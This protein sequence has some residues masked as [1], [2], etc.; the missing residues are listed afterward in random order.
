MADFRPIKSY[1][2]YIFIPS[3]QAVRINLPNAL[4]WRVR[5]REQ[6]T[7]GELEEGLATDRKKSA[8]LRSS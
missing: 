7:V 4:L 2:M 8:H 5:N 1:K 3:F 6:S